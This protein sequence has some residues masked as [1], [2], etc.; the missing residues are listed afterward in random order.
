MSQRHRRP[1]RESDSAGTTDPADLSPGGYVGSGIH[2]REDRP[3]LT[4]DASYLDDV[5]YPNTVHLALVRSQYASADLG[6]I[7]ASAALDHEEVLAVYTHEDLAAAGIDSGMPTD[8]PDDGVSPHYPILAR[9]RVRYQGQPIAAVVATDRYVA[10]DA[11][12]DVD[13]EYERREAVT[14]L[15]RAFDSDAPAVHE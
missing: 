6:A 15:D 5:E 1:S 9:D 10:H 11:V 13:V 12:A 8:S 3:L 7:D 2:R 4:G 14:E